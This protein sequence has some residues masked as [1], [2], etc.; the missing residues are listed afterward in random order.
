MAI[1][2]YEPPKRTI[3]LPDGQNF[4]VRALSLGDIAPIMAVNQDAIEFLVT[5]VGDRLRTGQLFD[6]NN[7][8]DMV[9]FTGMV[10]ELIRSSPTLVGALIA[11][12]SDEPSQYMRALHLPLTV[13]TEALQAIAELTFTDLAALERFIVSVKN[14]WRGM[15]PVRPMA[16]AS[17]A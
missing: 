15:V 8:Q 16:L 4:E 2:D 5:Q 17:A 13:Q 11:Y 10:G 6:P 12:A 1:A 14:I 7:P 9:F 3:P